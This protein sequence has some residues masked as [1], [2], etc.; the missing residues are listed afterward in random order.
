MISDARLSP[1]CILRVPQGVRWADQHAEE[2]PQTVFDALACP[3]LDAFLDAVTNER[4]RTGA[5]E[6]TVEGT[7]LSWQW[8]VWKLVVL[9]VLVIGLLIDCRTLNP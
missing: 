2:K 5:L 8:D 7:L 1:L 6:W 3:N 9:V 4:K